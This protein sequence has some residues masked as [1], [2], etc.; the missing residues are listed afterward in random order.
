[1]HDNGTGKVLPASEFYIDKGHGRVSLSTYCKECTKTLRQETLKAAKSGESANADAWRDA[2]GSPMRLDRFY[3]YTWIR[4]NDQTFTA[5]TPYYVGKGQGTR[6]FDKRNHH[7]PVPPDCKYVLIEERPDEASAFAREKELIAQYGRI[8]IGTGC[9]RNLTDGGDGPSGW[10]HSE[11]TLAKLSDAKKGKPGNSRGTKW[12]QASRDKLSASKTGKKLGP[13]RE[14]TKAKIRASNVGR[15]HAPMPEAAKAKIKA[16][17]SGIP[18]SPQAI[19]AAAAAHRATPSPLIGRTR[20]K[21][22]TEWTDNLSAAHRGKKQSPETIAKR[23]AAQ[24]GANH[25]RHRAWALFLSPLPFAL[26]A[27]SIV[28]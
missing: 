6:A 22:S 26:P 15:K 27:A 11:A 28:F 20:P 13:H 18:P 7:V 24:T 10:K 4:W 19:A 16:A 1:L 14:E 21:F 5:G 2:H 9:L 23:A 8:S 25:W 12:S 3:V 17:R